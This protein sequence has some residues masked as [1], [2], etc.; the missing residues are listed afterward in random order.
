[1]DK[2][3]VGIITLLTTTISYLK[4]GKESCSITHEETCQAII[5]L[6]QFLENKN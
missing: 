2:L 1:L 4:K 5:Q 3:E 6:R